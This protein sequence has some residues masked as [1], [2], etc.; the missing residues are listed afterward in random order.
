MLVFESRAINNSVAK[1]NC[2]LATIPK[3]LIS[4]VNSKNAQFLGLK[5]LYDVLYNFN[6][7]SGAI[8][9]TLVI[10]FMNISDSRLDDLTDKT[11]KSIQSFASYNKGLGGIL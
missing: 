8:S 10:N 11:V 6:E 5:N 7:E 9:K 2:T 1:T 3:E 4:G